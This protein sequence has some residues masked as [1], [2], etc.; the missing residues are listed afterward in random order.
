MTNTG[1]IG[2]LIYSVIYGLILVL[3]I[4]KVELFFY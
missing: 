1:L 3:G 4:I 2:N